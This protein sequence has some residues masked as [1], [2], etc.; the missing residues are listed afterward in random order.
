M[1][2]G[3][4]KTTDVLEIVDGIIKYNPPISYFY[5]NGTVKLKLKYDGGS[6]N[7]VTFSIPKNLIST[8]DIILKKDNENY[9][10]RKSNNYKYNDLPIASTTSLGGIIVGD[11]L[12]IDSN[13]KLNAQSGG[14]AATIQVGTT[15]TLAAGSQATVTQRGTTANPI[16]DF[17]IPKGID[18]GVT[19]YNNLTNKPVINLSS[20]DASNPIVL[21]NLD[22]GIYKLYGYIKYYPTYAGTT[23]ITSP[24]LATVSK[25]STTTYIQLLQPYGNEVTGYEITSASYVERKIKLDRADL[26]KNLFNK[27]D[28][29]NG[30]LRYSDN[31]LMDVTSTTFMTS[32]YIEVKPNTQ[33]TLNLVDATSLSSGG[34]MQY[35][36]NFNWIQPGISETQVVM[37]FTT[38]STTKYVRFVLRND[39]K[40]S[41]QMEE[42]SSATKYTPFAAY[43]VESGSNQY[44]TWT[45]YSD[46]TMI[47]SSAIKRDITFSQS[48]N[49]YT[50]TTNA[51]VYYPQEFTSMPRVISNTEWDVDYY[52]CAVYGMIRN[53]ISINSITFLRTTSPS[54]TV[55]IPFIYTAIGK[56]K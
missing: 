54:G 12:T 8:D 20:E 28:I 44:G 5:T 38:T 31:V 51:K 53:K 25:S 30:W 18:G 56:W 37:T 45:K 42:D 1:Q 55:E 19:D 29:V 11:N 40:D 46:G 16:F 23:A 41:I 49:V 4:T 32:G 15:T 13:G 52:Y 17:G 48:G 2:N 36:S 47:C 27:N 3:T 14:S 22:E 7:Y 6:S 26:F 35:D 43:I 10:V 24:T 21:Y 34:I 39:A 9:L 50:G 33:Y